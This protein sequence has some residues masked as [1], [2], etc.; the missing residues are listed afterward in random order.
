M[1]SKE[2]Y[3]LL[4]GQ[5]THNP[6]NVG[7]SFMEDTSKNPEKA[8]RLQAANKGLN[9]HFSKGS[10]YRDWLHDS[11][12]W[13]RRTMQ[14]VPGAIPYA[15][16]GAYDLLA[17]GVDAIPNYANL[18]WKS[19]LGKGNQWRDKKYLR[20][21]NNWGYKVGDW[22][23]DNV[24]KPVEQFANPV[25]NAISGLTSDNRNHYFD[26]PSLWQQLFGRPWSEKPQYSQALQ[27]AD[28]LNVMGMLEDTGAESILSTGPTVVK[29]IK[30]MNLREKLINNYL[31]NRLARKQNKFIAY[32]MI[33]E[34]TDL[35]QQQYTQFLENEPYIRD[36]LASHF[37]KT[38]S[39]FPRHP[40]S[41][42][43]RRKIKNF[44]KEYNNNPVQDIK[45]LGNVIDET[46]STE[47]I[48]YLF[49]GI[50][51]DY[52]KQRPTTL[53]NNFKTYTSPIVEVTF[54]YGEVLEMYPVHGDMKKDISNLVSS[55]GYGLRRATSYDEGIQLPD[56]RTVD[57]AMA[58]TSPDYE[59]VLTPA[60]RKKSYPQGVKPRTVVRLDSIY[61]D[62]QV[63]RE[64]SKP[65][66]QNI[67]NIRTMP[68]DDY[69]YMQKLLKKLPQNFH[70]YGFGYLHRPTLKLP[71]YHWQTDVKLPTVLSQTAI[72]PE[73]RRTNK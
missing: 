38:D 11:N 42:S 57:D 69:F 27:K 62:N 20:T 26:N 13:A 54:P 4:M 2:A 72:I 14:K 34:G 16:G 8:A 22:L 18:A 9:K 40:T 52:Y 41:L 25:G 64:L 29:N 48:N 71:S 53:P 49:R 35:T 30:I 60:M 19:M 3:D 31:N 43:A 58:F 50:N 47:D 51:A 45:L 68:V 44:V 37:S 32:K 46:N 70:N 63:V 7:P 59:V 73:S 5:P 17:N 67:K 56:P 39:A 61:P 15:I 12:T 33:P 6:Y 1:L 21:D 24:G 65:I 36:I 66:P 23:T 28:P 55:H 10:T